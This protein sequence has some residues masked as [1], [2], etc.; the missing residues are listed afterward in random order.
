[1]GILS[2]AVGHDVIESWTWTPSWLFRSY[3]PRAQYAFF[4]H[5]DIH[6][7]SIRPVWS[8]ITTTDILSTSCYIVIITFSELH[9]YLKS[10]LFGL[11]VLTLWTATNSFQKSVKLVNHT[12]SL[13][14]DR[15]HAQE[16]LMYLYYELKELSTSMNKVFGLFCFL[17]II[18]IIPYL[19][20]DLDF[21][22]RAFDWFD[23]LKMSRSVFFFGWNIVI[24]AET[25]RKV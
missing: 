22:L 24:S 3:V 10:L 23:A 7:T 13:Q 5:N 21:G 2:P 20:T 9:M 8:N 14:R 17:Y 6:L 19:A 18:D 12:E 11:T 25:Y 15:K 16:T 4:Y 1:M